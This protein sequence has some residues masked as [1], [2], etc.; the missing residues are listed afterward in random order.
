[1]ENGE[2]EGEE[3]KLKRKVKKKNREK[4]SYMQRET[5][6]PHRVRVSVVERLVKLDKQDTGMR[7]KVPCE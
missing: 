5:E 6:E 3:K 4:E 2:R 1:M 7:R